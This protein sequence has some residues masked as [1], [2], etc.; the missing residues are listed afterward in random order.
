MYLRAGSLTLHCLVPSD[1]A[2]LCRLDEDERV[3][4][5]LLDDRLT[6]LVAAMAMIGYVRQLYTTRPG[7]GVWLAR[8]EAGRFVGHFS[9]MP[10]GDTAR[11][12]IGVRLMPRAWGKYYPLVGG[13]AL[14]AHAFDR[15][16]L[17]QVHGYCHPENRAVPAILRR[18]GFEPRGSS[19]HFDKTALAFCLTQDRWAAR[20]R[21]A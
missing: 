13:R 9:L 15:L 7:L 21:A 12:E 3:T 16:D 20:Q 8:D 10:V 6:S 4:R 19:T 17:A 1:A 14:L 2:D 5:F 11:V 18:L